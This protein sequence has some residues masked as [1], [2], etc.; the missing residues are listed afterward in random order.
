MSSSRYGRLTTDWDLLTEDQRA[1][2]ARDVAGRPV[3]GSAL[4][5]TIGGPLG[6]GRLR[7]WTDRHGGG[8]C[9]SLA[10]ARV[11]WSLAD[12]SVV[13]YADLATGRRSLYAAMCWATPGELA[14]MLADPPTEDRP[15]DP[16]PRPLDE[17]DLW[18]MGVA[19]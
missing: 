2:W 3:E 11:C 1:A 5:I 4:Y 16:P 9:S 8:P 12:N 7:L 15:A 19:S 18:L 10:C 14:E 13:M 17:L 6:N